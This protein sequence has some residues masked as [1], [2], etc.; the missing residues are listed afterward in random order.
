MQFSTH[1]KQV[2]EL[3][4]ITCTYGPLVG[5]GPLLKKRTTEAYALCQ[6]TFM[7]AHKAGRVTA[8]FVDVVMQK[9][10]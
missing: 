10:L 1:N 9:H 6:H 5:G 3:P 4:K 8:K 2:K 7:S